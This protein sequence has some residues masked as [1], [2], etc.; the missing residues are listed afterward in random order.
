M[1]KVFIV[2]VCFLLSCGWSNAQ[3]F[4]GPINPDP[5][6][7]IGK[8]ANGMS[9]Y[10]RANKKPEKR[11]EFQLA[12]NAGSVQENDD[13]QGLAHFTEHMGFNGIKGYPGNSMI[14]E[15][16]KIGVSFGV[17][18]NAYTSFDRTV[19]MVQIPSDNPKNIKLGLDILY[20]WATAMIMDNKEIDDERGVISEEWRMGQGADDRMMQLW[21]PKVLANSRFAERL[22][23]GKIDII[24]NFNH[25][26]I[27]DF[28]KDW[29]RPDLQAIIIVGDINV[30]EMEKQ[31]IAKFGK[32]KPLKNPRPLIK[33]AI[34]GN[35]KP[36][37]AIC[38][39]PEAMG[40]TVLIARKFSHFVMK[41]VEDYRTNM[42]YELYN[43]MYDSRL[44]E[45]QQ[46]P[47]T[48]FLGAG[49][50]YFSFIGPLDVYGAQI[51]AK[52]N[53]ILESIAFIMKEDAR[54]LR[55]GFLDSELKRAKE[56][57][58]N[59]Y[60]EK[61]KEVDK[62]ESIQFVRS[63]VEHFLAGDPIPGAKRE[64]TYAKKY[65]ET[66]TLKDI[67]AM[68]KEWITQQNLVALIT[69][70]EKEGVKVPSEDEVLK[71]I[72]QTDFSNLEPYID[73]YKEQEV[74][75]IENL[76][77]GKVVDKKDIPEIDAQEW[78][79]SN[80]IKV[81][82]KK[83]D[84]K[85]EEITFAAISNGG[86]SLYEEKDLPSAFFASNFIDRAGIGELNYSALEKKLKGKK[87][88][89]SPSITPINE[90]LI[91]VTTP[92]DVEFF[93]QYV[94]AFFT[95]VRHDE[96]V[97]DLVINETKEQMKMILANPTYR[98]FAA[99][100]K[101][102][103]HD[104]PYQ[105]N[106]LTFT[107]EYV[108]QAN[109]ERAFEIYKERFA[110]PADF[111]FFFVGSFDEQMMENLLSKYVASL[112]VTDQKE[113]YNK[114]AFKDYPATQAVKDLYLGMDE[115]SWVGISY[116]APYAWNAKNNMIITEIG[117]ALEI[118]ALETIREKMGGVY[119]PMLN[120]SFEKDPFEKY[121][122]FIMFSCAPDNVTKLTDAVLDILKSFAEKGP[123]AET[124]S[125]VKEQLIKGHETSLESN[126]W[127][128]NAINTNYF[129][130]VEWS[131][132]NN[133][134]ERVT[135]VTNE[136]IVNFMKTYFVLNQYI[137]VTM[138]PENKK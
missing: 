2:I 75:D 96:N 43:I 100:F 46:D 76:V 48:P 80:G 126:T 52:E 137:K 73:N 45:Y 124:L 18:S 67:N 56:E 3:D 127:W 103:S 14:S 125:K 97:Y 95:N 74:I 111:T 109:Y 120:M 42:I 38:T 92:K 58:L 33:Y 69:A 22:P 51:A 4:S 32:I 116:E 37:V 9:Y 16:Q 21:L 129:N 123:K 131:Q 87:M 7:K 118:E 39:D 86:L 62:T 31:I 5:N 65:L 29:Y 110:N 88:S 132:M 72:F 114:A 115:K 77:S 8:L 30:A 130:G 6:V 35:E 59:N 66:I 63:Y 15:L 108:D 82:L 99:F 34:E 85:K 49:V 135:S 83:T 104:D 121:N 101:E 36:V 78:T 106:Q 98:F 90:S 122:L 55:Y 134:N 53:K 91:G 117:E 40:N 57:L 1:K 68:A 81:F 84:Y 102:V 138:Y 133:F 25:Q 79:L 119:S 27:K 50:G 71:L 11:I 54:V 12:V 61:A 94:N 24:R 107:D 20:G 70:P 17:H 44:S 23:I 128:R 89:L 93:F 10:L 113:V 26:T 105:K 47:K 60:E 28:Y 64:F 136:D 112:P 41:T 13:Q 19:Y